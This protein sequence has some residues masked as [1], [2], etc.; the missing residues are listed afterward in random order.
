M[1]TFNVTM[2]RLKWFEIKEVNRKQVRY[3]QKEFR[4]NNPINFVV[5]LK[6]DGKGTSIREII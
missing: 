3:F 6:S 2:D 1:A 4:E 5:A